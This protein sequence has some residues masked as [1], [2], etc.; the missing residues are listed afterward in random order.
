MLL[1][2]VPPSPSTPHVE[3]RALRDRLKDVTTRRVTTLIAGAGYGK[4]TLLA[5]WAERLNCVWYAVS[6]EDESLATFGG[7]IGHAL[8]LRVPAAVEEVS[9]A[10]TGRI[11]PDAGVE[12][13]ERA[14][15]VAASLCQ[16]LLETLSRDLV[17]VLDDIHE[18][19]RSSDA[20][21]LIESLCRHAP[22]KLHI[23]LSGRSDPGFSLDRMRGRGQVN[24]LTAAEL[25]F[26]IQEITTLLELTLGSPAEA[27]AGEVEALTQG[28]PAA[29]RL[30][31]EAL[32]G[33][34]AEQW[35]AELKK[36]RNPSGPLFDYLVHEIIDRE[37]PT[38]KS[39]IRLAAMFTRCSGPLLEALG[40]QGATQAL[41]NLAREGVFIETAGGEAVWFS[42]SQLM[43]DYA[44]AYFEHAADEKADL[45]RQAARWF[46]KNNEVEE[47]MESWVIAEEPGQVLRLIQAHGE[48]LLSAGKIDFLLRVIDQV[49]TEIRDEHCERVR[50]DA[51]QSRGDLEGA[52]NCFELSMKHSKALDPATAWR[53]GVIHYLRGDPGRA[54]DVFGRCDIARGRAEDRAL[55]LGWKATAQWITGD[56]AHCRE[57]TVEAE[58]QAVEA[59][60]DRALSTVH[61][62]RAMLA[63]VDGDRRAN[64]LHYLRALEYAEAAQDALQITR[65]RVNRA[66][67]HMEEGAYQEALAELQVAITLADLGGFASFKGIA[68]TN[69]GQTLFFLGRLDEAISDLEAAK[70]MYQRMG[71]ATISY[72]LGTLGDVYRERGD[73]A[74][75]RAS[76]EEA[77]EQADN[78]HDIQGAVPALAGLARVIVLED[79][80]A[81][82]ALATRAVDYGPGL[83]FVIALL[84]SGWVAAEGDEMDKALA[85]SDQAATE[86][87]RRR[88]RSGLAE[89][90]ELRSRAEGRTQEAQRSIDEARA[91]WAQLGNTLA[92]ARCD[93]ALARLMGG[94]DGRKLAR[95]ALE[96]LTALGSRRYAQAAR[97][98]LDELEHRSHTPVSIQSLG[99][100]RVLREGI[101]V[102]RS[103]WQSKKARDL[104]KILVARRGRPLAREV[105]MELLW[106]EGD[107]IHVASRL[108]VTLTIVRTIL[109]PDRLHDTDYFVAADRTSVGLETERLEIDVLSFLEIAESGLSLLSEKKD[110]EAWRKLA[111]AEATYGGD[112]LEE[113]P[114]EDWA[115]PLREEA[116]ATYVRVLRAL[117]EVAAAQDAYD[118]VL[119]YQLRILEQDPYDERS[120]LILVQTMSLAGRHGEARRH[121]RTYCSRMAEIDVE[122]EPFPPVRPTLRAG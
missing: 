5:E 2:V 105:L 120:H 107:P 113:D 46:E 62:V 31:V 52:L 26:D 56:F 82:T 85:Y 20:A 74:Q 58:K 13:S 35:S 95:E 37:D 3:R 36:I 60:S 108:S 91:I 83:A 23:V 80:P 9:R 11:G 84:A 103:E 121:Y 54:L 104:L 22:A 109:D 28:W 19:P 73:F 110:D 78:S 86:A 102:P 1:K 69:R 96:V 116:R 49:P 65:I 63:A 7:G 61:T 112:F 41:R 97:S 94:D 45:H 122:A 98:V 87:R 4:S 43:R 39:L 51:L 29:V 30:T 114:Y 42:L 38:S 117:S 44:A 77:I 55:L 17:L 40:Q 47:A 75:A 70:T 90:L 8:R 93:V 33:R 57:S 64:D 111:G 72:P 81:A 88:D 32:R 15:A 10:L 53:I 92:A 12:P 101:L 99:G 106:P 115:I 76:Y 50:G 100:F 18:I 14:D 25:R 6:A 71:S 16:M 66:S 79:Q 48:A 89:A 34:P 119:R 59:K 118:A 21:H 67:R 68:L 27:L 24:D